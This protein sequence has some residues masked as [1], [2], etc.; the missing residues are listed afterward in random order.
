MKHRRPDGIA[1]YRAPGAER[2]SRLAVFLDTLPEGQLTFTR[3]YGHGRGCAVGLAA[4]D[5]LW[6]QAQGLGLEQGAQSR[7]SYPVYEGQ[8]DWPAVA[9]FFAL[10]LETAQELF[11]ARGYDGDLRPS[12]REIAARV[13][14]HLRQ[15]TRV[16]A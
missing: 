6:M 12:P 14:L 2:L 10:P 7:M 4:H 1:R 3:W 15:D 8:T 5:D 16:T 13:R 9:A 11:S